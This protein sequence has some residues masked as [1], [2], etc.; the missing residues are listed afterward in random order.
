MEDDAISHRISA[1]IY[2]Q[3]QFRVDFQGNL[4]LEK[5]VEFADKKVFIQATFYL[6]A[7][8]MK[9][10]TFVFSI[11]FFGENSI[12]IQQ[13]LLAILFQTIRLIRIF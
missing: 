12:L 4:K 3:Q 9:M 8:F 1:D 11:T 10:K 5:I 13:T 7:T 2:D 6:H